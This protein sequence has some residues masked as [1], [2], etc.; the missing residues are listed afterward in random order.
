MWKMCIASVND[1][2][3]VLFLPYLKVWL[4]VTRHLKQAPSPIR[5]SVK[6]MLALADTTNYKY[7]SLE[8]MIQFRTHKYQRCLPDILTSHSV[9][10]DNWF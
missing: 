5:A 1:M 3:Y 7:L 6:V 10:A 2:Y 4:C 8:K 9:M